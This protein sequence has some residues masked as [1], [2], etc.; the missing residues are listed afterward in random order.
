MRYTA[1]SG[2]YICVYVYVTQKDAI[3]EPSLLGRE[4]REDTLSHERRRSTTEAYL[5]EH[6]CNDVFTHFRKYRTRL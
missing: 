3:C 2:R 6:E 4:H 5:A 1:D